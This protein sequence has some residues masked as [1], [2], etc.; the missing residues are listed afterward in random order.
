MSSDRTSRNSPPTLRAIHILPSIDLGTVPEWFLDL[1]DT[2]PNPYT[3]TKERVYAIL[4]ARLKHYQEGDTPSPE[5]IHEEWTKLERVIKAI[6]DP[7]DFA[8]SLTNACRPFSE[9]TV[10]SSRVGCCPFAPALSFPNST[11]IAD[12]DRELQVAYAIRESLA[13][14][15]KALETKID[16]AAACDL[17][18][19]GSSAGQT[20]HHQEQKTKLQEEL[21]SLGDEK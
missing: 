19:E 8:S 11:S 21:D 5:I 1:V 2:S 9:G 4:F 10:Y 15:V 6:V 18:A 17:R 3:I 12:I 20:Q 14:E 7:F 13:A 16:E